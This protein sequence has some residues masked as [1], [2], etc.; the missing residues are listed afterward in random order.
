MLSTEQYLNEYRT[1]VEG[2][3]PSPKKRAN[4]RSKINRIRL[5]LRFMEQGSRQVHTWLFLSRFE[6]IYE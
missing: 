4:V 6:R 5:F 1:Y 3:R 2:F